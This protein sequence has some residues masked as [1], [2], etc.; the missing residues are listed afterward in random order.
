MEQVKAFRHSRK[1][2]MRQTF[3]T[4]CE[5]VLMGD[6][7]SESIFIE[8]FLASFAELQSDRIVNVRLY[9]SQVLARLFESKRGNDLMSQLV[10]PY[11][12]SLLCQEPRIV[13]MVRRLRVDSNKDTCFFL[14]HVRL[15]AEADSPEKN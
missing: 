11:C 9:A 3:I 6:A 7:Q 1:Y 10:A 2:T 5:S 12:D 15:P 14:R 13:N 8:H 4:M